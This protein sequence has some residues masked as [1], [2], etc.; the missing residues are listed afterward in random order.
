M[1][2]PDTNFDKNAV[3]Q[4]I[5]FNSELINGNTVSIYKKVDEGKVSDWKGTSDRSKTTFKIDEK[6]YNFTQFDTIKF[7]SCDNI[8]FDELNK[9]NNFLKQGGGARRKSSR[10]KSNKKKTRR[11]RRKSI[12]R[13]RRH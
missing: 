8:D 9:N 4:Y 1:N 5:S 6:E 2:C 13:N 7:K 3:S 12:R 10:R 11:N